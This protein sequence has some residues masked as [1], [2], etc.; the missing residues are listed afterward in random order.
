MKNGLKIGYEIAWIGILW[1]LILFVKKFLIFIYW[2]LERE[3][4]REKRTSVCNSNSWHIHWLLLICTLTGDW[5][6]NLGVLGQYSNQLSSLART[7]VLLESVGPIGKDQK[8]T[9]FLDSCWWRKA[10]FLGRV[11]RYCYCKSKHKVDL[12]KMDYSIM[13]LEHYKWNFIVDLEV[14][15]D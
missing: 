3:E 1:F 14:E 10:V 9:V 6:C 5:T 11:W 7:T 12:C 8:S 15:V 4:G 13:C 2:C